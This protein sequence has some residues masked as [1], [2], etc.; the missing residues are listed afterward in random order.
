M[1]TRF[2]PSIVES[3]AMRAK[4]PNALHSYR[5]A[6]SHHN[7]GNAEKRNENIAASL[8]NNMMLISKILKK[9]K[10][11]MMPRC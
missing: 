6:S 2:I 1:K 4:R 7:D 8:I 11:V 10:L 9:A 3:M 5:V